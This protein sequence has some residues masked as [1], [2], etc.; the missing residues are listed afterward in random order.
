MH[1]LKFAQ[2]LAA[3]PN[4]SL[5]E[6]GGNGGGGGEC[7]LGVASTVKLLLS[8]GHLSLSCTGKK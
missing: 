6:V 8:G 2:I 5:L 4:S 3:Q 7:S 1:K